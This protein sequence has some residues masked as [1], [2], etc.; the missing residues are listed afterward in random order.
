MTHN[1]ERDYLAINLRRARHARGL[2]QDDIATMSGVNRAYV[3]DLER[4]RRNIGI[5]CIG[6]IAAALNVPA[7]SLLLPTEKAQAYRNRLI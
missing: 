3:S 2:T 4:S 7:A 5:D 6:R 1:I